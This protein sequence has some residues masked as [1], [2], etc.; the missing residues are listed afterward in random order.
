MTSKAAQ[1]G[2]PTWRD[3]CIDCVPPTQSGCCSARQAWATEPA[4]EGG[5][6]KRNRGREREGGK[7]QRKV[8]IKGET[9]EER[10]VWPVAKG[11]ALHTR[12]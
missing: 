3:V 11:L 5:N 12:H 4:G 2:M 8:R 10:E 6:R 7:R 9:M 1:L